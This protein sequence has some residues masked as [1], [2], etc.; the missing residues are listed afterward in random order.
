[1]LG[2]K[3]WIQDITLLFLSFDSTGC[4]QATRD[5]LSA[6][7]KNAIEIYVKVDKQLKI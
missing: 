7:F 1:M 3:N 2:E 6:L 4:F 5:L